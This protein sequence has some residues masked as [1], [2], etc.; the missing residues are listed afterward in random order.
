MSF[1]FLDTHKF[2]DGPYTHFIDFAIFAAFDPSMGRV[3]TLKKIFKKNLSLVEG[4]FLFW[5]HKGSSLWIYRFR[6]LSP[7]YGEG[8]ST[9]KYF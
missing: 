3:P 6:R 2:K 5:T 8:I 1:P 4:F 7:F 9:E